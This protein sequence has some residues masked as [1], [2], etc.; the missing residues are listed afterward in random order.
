MSFRT[1][2]A[3]CALIA[4]SPA[5]AETTVYLG[6]GADY[7]YPHSG[8]E[9]TFGSFI[10]GAT[11]NV[12]EYMG[13]GIEGE[14]AESIGGDDERETARVRGLLTYDFG[15]VM[16]FASIGTVQYEVG[17][18]TF[19]GD[20]VGIGAQMEVL[21]GF[22]GRFE[23]MRDFIDDEFGTNVTTSRLALLYKF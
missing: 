8:D 3:A 14:V 1:A 2:I 20:T 21:N 4:A 18:A 10:G 19:D 12:W 5:A 23:I 17:A 11:F 6:F 15:R 22:D 13:L 9:L 7:A 16:G